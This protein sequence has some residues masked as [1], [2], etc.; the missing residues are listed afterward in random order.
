MITRSRFRI[1]GWNVFYNF[2]HKIR[3]WAGC[4]TTSKGASHAGLSLEDSLAYIDE[5]YTDYLLYSGLRS[6]DLSGRRVL[7]VGPGDNFGV[8]L[9]FLADG[10]SQVVCLDKFFARRDEAQ[11]LRIYRAMRDSLTD[12]WRQRF[13]QAVDLTTSFAPDPEKLRYISGLPLEQAAEQLPAQSFDWIVSRAVLMEI[14]DS[15]AAFRSMDRL[16]KPGG[17]MIHKIA[18]IHDYRMFRAYGYGPLEFL[19]VPAWVYQ[20]MVSDCGGPNRKPVNYYRH[21]MA[22]LGYEATVHIV[23]LVGS[24]LK[25]PPDV[26]APPVGSLE[27]QA[28]QEQIRSIRP[29]LAPEFHA[30]PDEDLMVEDLFLVGRKPLASRGW[31]HEAAMAAAAVAR[32]RQ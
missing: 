30:I 28:A 27:Y 11:H 29:R 18:P 2:S 32:D 5:V 7:E 15:D 22:E 25:F 13:D 6:E 31:Q 19:T 24:R 3:T 1:I 16:L 26:I 21:K 8:A 17:C 14:P 23:N 10:C 9:R 4:I 12:P 20:R